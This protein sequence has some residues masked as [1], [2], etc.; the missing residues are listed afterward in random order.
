MIFRDGNSAE[1]L[2]NLDIAWA[3]G[4]ETFAL[5]P[6]QFD[7][8]DDWIH[9]SLSVLPDA[10]RR[11]HALLATSGSTGAPK[12]L[13]MNRARAEGMADVIGQHQG[14][15]ALDSVIITL[16]LSYCF[17]F[18]NQWVLSRRFRLK[19]SLARFSEPASLLYELQSAQAGMVCLVAAQVPLLS[20]LFPDGGPHSFPGIKAVAFAGS[21]FPWGH[22][23][24]LT[25]LFP[26]ARFFNNYGCAEAMPRLVVQDVTLQVRRAE[27]PVA[28]F[29]GK[30]LPGI[31]FRRSADGEL[32][33]Q[34]PYA[35]L[36]SVTPDGYFPFATDGW[37]GTGDSADCD[38]SGV[39]WLRGRTSE[40]F[41][42]HGEKVSLLRLRATIENVWDKLYALSPAQD[43]SGEAGVL[44]V[45]A[46]AADREVAR[47]VLQAIRNA[48]PRAHWPLQILRVDSIP[49]LNNG[50]IDQQALQA[51]HDKQI[52][53]DQ[54]V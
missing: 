10:L 35:A 8:S 30:P 43:R 29:L 15:D 14:A 5:L 1:L 50:K 7:Q 13:V 23:S 31:R 4:S 33:F 9:Q 21:P 32:T 25:R 48:H 37:I 34:S 20:Q 16:P 28:G 12:L 52:L 19:R 6:Q 26:E 40:V 51:M 44:L 45:L 47:A 17:S 36:G 2:E 53:W 39:W 41:K 54:R 18:V 22:V 11:D 46:G 42:R 38:E 27:P 49:Q 24:L 3:P